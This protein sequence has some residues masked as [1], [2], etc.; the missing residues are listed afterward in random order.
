MDIN[1]EICLT[2]KESSNA[3]CLNDCIT[4]EEATLIVQFTCTK[5]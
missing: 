1:G 4:T 2:I 3:N 5:E